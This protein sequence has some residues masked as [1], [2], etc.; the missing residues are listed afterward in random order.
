MITRGVAAGADAARTLKDASRDLPL[1]A[2]FEQI[3]RKGMSGEWGLA[4][5]GVALESAVAALRRLLL[6]R[7][8]EAAALSARVES[9]VERACGA[10]AVGDETYSCSCRR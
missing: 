2:P 5:I 7:R 3:V 1:P 8:S 10:S 9:R 4:Q 6:V